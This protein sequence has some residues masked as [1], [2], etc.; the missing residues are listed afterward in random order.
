MLVFFELRVGTME[1]DFTMVHGKR[2]RS[3]H[4]VLLHMWYTSNLRVTLKMGNSSKSVV[5]IIS[6]TNHNANRALSLEVVV[7]N[8]NRL[9]V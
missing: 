8:L 4:K 2:F 7:S 3:Q 5:L 6:G 9:A 1:N